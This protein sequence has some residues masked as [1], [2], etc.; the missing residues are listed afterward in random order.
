MI[1]IILAFLIGVVFGVGI[2]ISGMANP[3]KIL[4]F[5]DVFGHWDPSLAFVM[6]GALTVTAI[7]YHLLFKRARPLLDVKFHVPTR[8]DLDARLFGG[9]AL[10]GVGWGIVGFCPGGSIPALAVGRLEPLIFVA[11][12]LAGMF[13]ARSKFLGR[14]RLTFER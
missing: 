2:L 10:F 5:F 4:N 3:A 6:G 1:R 12:L 9:A 14:L 11:A 8:R 7:G 13:A